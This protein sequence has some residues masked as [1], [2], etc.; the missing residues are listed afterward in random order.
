MN[1]TRGTG[2]VGAGGEAARS[3]AALM[4]RDGPPPVGRLIVWAEG[5][6]Q[7]DTSLSVE[8]GSSSS[9]TVSD[10][11]VADDDRG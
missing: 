11:S 10:Q 4:I 7:P 8:V 6:D 5:R 3:V 2:S 1:R 9:I